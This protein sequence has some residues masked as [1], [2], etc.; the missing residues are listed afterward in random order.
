MSQALGYKLA[1]QQRVYSLTCVIVFGHCRYTP[2]CYLYSE[3]KL[4]VD[5]VCNLNTPI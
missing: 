3:V 5:G 1:K 4:A 2:T